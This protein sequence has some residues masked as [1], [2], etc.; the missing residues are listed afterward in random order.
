MP[1]HI[2]VTL[3]LDGGVRGF[4]VQRAAGHANV[5]TTQDHYSLKEDLEGNP[6]DYI[7]EHVKL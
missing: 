3:A 4:R 5:T 1:R 2:F 6:S 7:L